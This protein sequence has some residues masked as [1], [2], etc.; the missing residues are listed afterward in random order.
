MPIYMGVNGYVYDMTSGG[1]FY[2][3]GGTYGF[4]TGHYHSHQNKHT[5]FDSRQNHGTSFNTMSQ[6]L[7]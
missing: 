6:R 3:P 7:H 1:K 5:F 2:G 4:M